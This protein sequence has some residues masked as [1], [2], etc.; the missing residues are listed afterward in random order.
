[1][2][3]L[4]RMMRTK[5]FAEGLTRGLLD[6]SCMYGVCG[7]IL[8]Q[9][10]VGMRDMAFEDHNGERSTRVDPAL[11]DHCLNCLLARVRELANILSRA[12]RE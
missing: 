11:E 12:L 9:P 4:Y 1:V 10:A 8:T 7:S 3:D 2:V 6:R 5:G